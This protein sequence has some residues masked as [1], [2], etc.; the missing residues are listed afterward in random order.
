V[1]T[2]ALGRIVESTINNVTQQILYGPTGKL[3]FVNG[4]TMTKI[5]IPLPGGGQAVYNGGTLAKF[6]HPDWQGNI[7]VAS[8]AA[9]RTLAGQSEY[10]PFGMPYN[11]APAGSAGP[12]FNQSYGDVFDSHEYDSA[13]REL[14]PVQGRWIQPDFA[15]LSAVDPSN[16][17]S[18][19]R[20]A[21]VMNNPLSNVDPTGLLDDPACSHTDAGCGGGSGDASSSGNFGPGGAWGDGSPWNAWGG[22]P[23]GRLGGVPVTSSMLQAAFSS[24]FAVTCQCQS[25]DIVG[26]NN[27]IYRWSVPTYGMVYTNGGPG[28]IT[29]IHPGGWQQVGSAGGWFDSLPLLAGISRLPQGMDGAAQAF[30]Q[31]TRGLPEVSPNAPSSPGNW[32]APQTWEDLDPMAKYLQEMLRDATA[33]LDAVVNGGSGLTVLFMISP[34]TMGCAGYGSLPC[35]NGHAT[36]F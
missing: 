33:G 21:Y 34:S 16:P 35:G 25:G 5:R 4:Q 11:E 23:G 30:K 20:Y 19:N 15:G 17:Q 22:D 3:G 13:T 9:T 24:G 29:L 18:W 7:R 8:K 2:D 12:S 14:H 31:A 27:A 32:Q 10:T 1:V 6:N 36:S 28:P 26:A